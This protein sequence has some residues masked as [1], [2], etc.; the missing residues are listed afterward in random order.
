MASLL[1]ART[2][3]RQGLSL[4]HPAACLLRHAAASQL[5]VG[6][7]LGTTQSV[8]SYLDGGQATV[9]ADSK[10]RTATPSVVAHQLNAVSPAAAN[11]P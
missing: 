8:V 7:D 1:N 9:I 11:A 10:G 5:A 6:I 3:L 4:A 2:A